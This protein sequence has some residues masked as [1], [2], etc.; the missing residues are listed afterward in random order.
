MG[1]KRG[2]RASFHHKSDVVWQRASA[3]WDLAYEQQR[4]RHKLT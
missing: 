4:V 3:R 1:T 2:V